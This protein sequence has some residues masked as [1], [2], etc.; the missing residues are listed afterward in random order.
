MWNCAV[1]DFV[2]ASA[3]G[4]GGWEAHPVT[5]VAVGVEKPS[6]ELDAG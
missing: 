4:D 3:L 5:D 6:V 1:W 2:K